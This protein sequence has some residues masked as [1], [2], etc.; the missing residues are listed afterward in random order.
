MPPSLN[1]FF[2]AQD[3]VGWVIDALVHATG[4]VGVLGLIVGLVVVVPLW[5]VSDGDLAAPTVATTLLGGMLIPLLP[6][7]YAALG[8]SI[9]IIG[10]VSGLL[11]IARSYVLNP[12]S[13][14]P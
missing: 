6:P 1:E 10:G 8:T 5:Y 9:L 13:G 4:G 11:A 3:K 2:Q 7:E 14:R 12:G